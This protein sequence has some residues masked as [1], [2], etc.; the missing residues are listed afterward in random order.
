MDANNKKNPTT[1]RQ[2]LRHRKYANGHATRLQR[3]LSTPA[4]SHDGRETVTA[5]REWQPSCIVRALLLELVAINLL[6]S[7][8]LF[9]PASVAFPLAISGATRHPKVLTVRV[10]GGYWPVS[11]VCVFVCV[12]PV[13]F[14]LTVSLLAS[15]LLECYELVH[16]QCSTPV[17][18]EVSISLLA[19]GAMV[20]GKVRRRFG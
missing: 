9:F 15:V 7:F 11:G 3:R 10:V 16:A 8:N 5:Q 14:F 20:W 1:Q 6:N 12:F 19:A 18:E 2:K 17:C 4:R 13:L